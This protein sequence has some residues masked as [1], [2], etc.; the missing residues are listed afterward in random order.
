MIA[1]Y[2]GLAQETVSRTLTKFKRSGIISETHG[3]HV[4]LQHFGQLEA[5]AAGLADSKSANR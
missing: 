4:L 5:L 1:D 2:T 3:Q